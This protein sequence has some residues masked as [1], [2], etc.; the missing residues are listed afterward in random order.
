MGGWEGETGTRGRH[1]RVGCAQPGSSS[2]PLPI[3]TSVGL[4]SPWGWVC[5]ASRAAHYGA[6]APIFC[7]ILEWAEREARLPNSVEGN[8]GGRTKLCECLD[9]LEVLFWNAHSIPHGAAIYRGAKT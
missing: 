4:Q 9:E 6:V 2:S 1:H 5:S 7:R 3:S 8:L